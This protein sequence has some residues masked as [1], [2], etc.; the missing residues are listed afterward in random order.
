M[1]LLALVLHANEVVSSDKLID[2][3]WGER[4]PESAPKLVQGFVSSLR[5]VLGDGRLETRAPGYRLRVEEGERDVDRF[6]ALLAEARSAG[7][8]RAGGLVAEA[9]SLWRGPP[10]PELRDADVAQPEFA[11]LEGLRQLGLEL[12]FEAQLALG[13]H[14]EA[15]PDLERFVAAEPLRERPR[16]QLMVALYRSGRQADALAVYAAGRR[17]L[18]DELGIEPSA[19]LR[20]LERQILA[21]DPALELEPAVAAVDRPAGYLPTPSTP[22]LGR[23]R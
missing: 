10:L 4:P 3:L 2:T 17:T 5:R 12:G 22:F 11:R 6:E 23:A 16:A 1:L 21:H 19:A 8:E 7:P 14:R 9:L 18:V 13:R 15:L 20:K